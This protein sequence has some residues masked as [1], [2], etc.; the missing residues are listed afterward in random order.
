MGPPA[1]CHPGTEAPGLLPEAMFLS[2]Y[3][4]L[5]LLSGCSGADYHKGRPS[6]LKPASVGIWS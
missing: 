2:P 3:I 6:I 1:V 5:T 4:H